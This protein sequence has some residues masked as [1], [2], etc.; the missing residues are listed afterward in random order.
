ME[1]HERSSGGILDIL[2]AS[3]PIGG[4]LIPAT[5]GVFSSQESA[6]STGRAVPTLGLLLQSGGPVGA[7]LLWPYV[8]SSVQGLG[9]SG[10]PLPTV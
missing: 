1:C 5:A 7:H 9:P 4:P 2:L 6:P 8:Q 3:H 10:A